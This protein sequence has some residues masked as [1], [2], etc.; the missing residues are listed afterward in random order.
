MRTSFY[1]LL[2]EYKC[3][4]SWRW[5][6][7]TSDRPLCLTSL[8]VWDYLFHYVNDNQSS[9]PCHKNFC[10]E[11]VLWMNLC[12]TNDVVLSINVHKHFETWIYLRVLEDEEA[13][14]K[15]WNMSRVLYFQIR[16]RLK[17][18]SSMAEIDYRNLY[19]ASLNCQ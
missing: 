17:M 13:H 8:S 12:L 19:S 3:S 1:Y 15:I 10:F 4:L 11:C 5:T 16:L 6:W 18:S 7:K 2:N 9:I 14:P